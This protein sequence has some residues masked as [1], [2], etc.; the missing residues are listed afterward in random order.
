MRR[1]A[2]IEARYRDE[3][4][5][6]LITLKALTYQP[7]RRHCRRAHDLASRERWAACAIGTTATV[8]C[9]MRR[10]PSTFS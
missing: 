10:S 8:G 1:C 3:V 6:S 5:R 9:G 2:R 4:L 7:H